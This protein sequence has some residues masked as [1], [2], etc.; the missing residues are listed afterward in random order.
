[1]H[2]TVTGPTSGACAGPAAVELKAGVL[3]QV[4]FY[5][6]EDAPGYE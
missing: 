4:S 5:C 3:T 2:I 1:V 6:D